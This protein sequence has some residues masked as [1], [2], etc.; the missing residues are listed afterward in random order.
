MALALPLAAT[1]QCQPCHLAQASTQLKSNHALALRPYDGR[2]FAG[3]RIRERGGIE[4]AFSAQGV[5]IRAGGATR[6]L[7]IQWLFGAGHFGAT[8][9]LLEEGE[10][11]E[12]RLSWYSRPD[13]LSLTPGHPLRPASDM[14]SAIGVVQSARNATRCF[15]CHATGVT[16][17]LDK[18]TPG[19][20]CQRCHGDGAAHNAKPSKSSV[21]RDRTVAAC[22]ECH[23]APGRDYISA[24]PEIEDPVSVRF[25]PVGLSA[26]VCYQ[27]SKKLDCVTC[28]DPHANAAPASAASYR[29]ACLS[30]HAPVAKACPRTDDCVG[31][32]MPKA[33]PAP[34]LTFTDHR[35]RRPTAR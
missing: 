9:L 10:W 27:R 25:A 20:V 30:C 8:P 23:R 4:Y 15:S 28:H 6:E 18:F 2:W 35:I 19:V 16:A 31:C 3:K 24:M 32:H 13:Q 7:P 21:R 34:F 14:A 17:K 5:A 26:S 22:A 33:T 11:V 12:H 29:A 1:S